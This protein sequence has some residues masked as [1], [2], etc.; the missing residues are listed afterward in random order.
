MGESNYKYPYNKYTEKPQTIGEGNVTTKAE[1]GIIWPQV[2]GHL[3][4]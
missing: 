2:Q 3:Q 4:L 1:I